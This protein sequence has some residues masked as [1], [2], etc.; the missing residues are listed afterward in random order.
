MSIPRGRC[1]EGGVHDDNGRQYERNG[2]L[3]TCCSKCGRVVATDDL[4][5]DDE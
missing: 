4:S 3:Y 2:K 1:P 5:E